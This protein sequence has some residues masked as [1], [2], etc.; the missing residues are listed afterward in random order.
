MD[1]KKIPDDY[2]LTNRQKVQNNYSKDYDKIH[3]DWSIRN[4]NH[5]VNILDIIGM[6]YRS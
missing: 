4:R 1:M 3:Q 2:F 5:V 6:Y